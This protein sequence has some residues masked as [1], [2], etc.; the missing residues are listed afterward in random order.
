MAKKHGAQVEAYKL[1]NIR[2]W[3]ATQMV[4]CSLVITC[5]LLQAGSVHILS[6]TCLIW[7]SWQLVTLLC[8]A[9][10]WPMFFILDS[11]SWLFSFCSAYLFDVLEQSSVQITIIEHWRSSH[12]L[13]L[14]LMIIAVICYSGCVNSGTYLKVK[15]QKPLQFV[16]SMCREIS[17]A[18]EWPED[19]RPRDDGRLFW[20]F[21]SQQLFPLIIT[22][23]G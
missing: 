16:S 5:A 15:F 6:M 14:M 21:C 10:P 17:D 2:Y 4:Y 9:L 8:E 23:T 18:Q 1:Q 3:R 20:K 11:Q 22:K 7:M 19:F 12:S 13:A